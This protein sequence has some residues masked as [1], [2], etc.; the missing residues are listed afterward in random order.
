MFLPT[1]G[2][3]RGNGHNYYTISKSRLGS[4]C[5]LTE[6]A[7][8]KDSWTQSLIVSPGGRGHLSVLQCFSS[9]M[10]RKMSI[11]GEKGFESMLHLANTQEI[12][13]H[14]LS[15]KN[16]EG[17]YRK[18]YQEFELLEQ[19]LEAML[20]LEMGKWEDHTNNIQ[21]QGPGWHLRSSLRPE[22]QRMQT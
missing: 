7:L 9:K 1:T 17:G 6:V 19:I 10:I 12:M 18:R 2:V 13:I 11:W 5:L 20:E 14:A 16:F 3:Y 21:N 4:L 15:G 8:G 22:A